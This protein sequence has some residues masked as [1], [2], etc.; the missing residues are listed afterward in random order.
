M[1]KLAG[2]I[3]SLIVRV[4]HMTLRVRHVNAQVAMNTPR[5]VFAFW[6]AHML[7]MLHSRYRRPITVLSSTSRDGDLAVW[8]YKT[9]GVRT[10]RGSS[11]RG[12]QAAMRELIRRA[13]AGSNLAFTPDGP[14]GPPRVVKEG[15]I[16][17]AQMTGLPI[18]P[19]AFAA[20][21]KKSLHSWD[22][23]T[24]AKPFSRAIYLYGDPIVIGRHDDGEKMRQTLEKALNALADRVENNFED[25]WRMGA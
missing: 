22:T 6:H 21:R 17:A 9:Y 20:A 3:L 12:G 18:I 14:T 13:R 25:V 15:V 1:M 4:L 8:A 19:V 16:F 24:V 23:M 7:L 5:Y 2:V 11:T 10:V